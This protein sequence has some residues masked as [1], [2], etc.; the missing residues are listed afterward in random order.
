MVAYAAE[1]DYSGGR[2]GPEQPPAGRP[3]AGDGARRA[4][5]WPV[6][7]GARFHVEPS[8]SASPTVDGRIRRGLPVK[9][10]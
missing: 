5:S 1:G 6:F 10:S 3:A 4:R 7:R 2:A 8:C 9:T